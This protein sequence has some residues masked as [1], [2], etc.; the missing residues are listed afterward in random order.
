MDICTYI[1]IYYRPFTLASL[2]ASTDSR[3][4][5]P[6]LVNRPNLQLCLLSSNW[7]TV[8]TLVGEELG[9]SGN[10]ICGRN[11]RPRRPSQIWIFCICLIFLLFLHLALAEYQASECLTLCE[12]T[13]LRS[14]QQRRSFRG[15]LDW[16]LWK[17]RVCCVLHNS[18]RAGS[19]AKIPWERTGVHGMEPEKMGSCGLYDPRPTSIDGPAWT[20]STSLFLEHPRG[21]FNSAKK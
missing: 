13:L 19:R 2:P 6:L 4:G 15:T 7:P 17:L 10:R 18:H 8:E 16:W 5:D 21:I 20:G 1:Y 9:N 11:R 12:L 14:F 3:N